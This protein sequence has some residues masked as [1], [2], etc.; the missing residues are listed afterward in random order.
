MGVI[1]TKGIVLLESNMGDY[2][3]MVT[4]LTPDL[5]KIGCSAKGSRRPKSTL[6]AGTQYLSFCEFVIYSGVSTYS[7]NSAEP[8][9]VFYNIRT[10]L[11]KLSYAALI[12]RIAFDVTYENQNTYRILQLVLNSLYM[13][14]ETDKNKDFILAVFKLKLMQF[15]GLTPHLSSCINCDE[16]SNLQF[17]SIQNSGL[18]CITCA[19]LDKSAIKISEDTFNSL[20]YIYSCDN[21]KLFSFDC[22]EDSKKELNLISTLYLNTSLDKNYKLEKY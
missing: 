20:K 11:D 9:E 1:K 5:G 13:L 12:S 2:D 18:E 15:L 22:S 3:K 14:S 17:F 8:I 7:I 10:D 4:L 19:K 21:K 6:L 16:T